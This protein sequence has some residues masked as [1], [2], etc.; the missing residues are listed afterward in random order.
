MQQLGTATPKNQTKVFF[1]HLGLDIEDFE[2]DDQEAILSTFYRLLESEDRGESPSSIR[3]NRCNYYAPDDILDIPIKFLVELVNVD[4]NHETFEYYHAIPALLYRKDWSKP[5]SKKE[6][7][8]NQELYYTAPLIFSLWAVS[9]F[10]DLIVTLQD[11]YP[12][13]YKGDTSEGSKEQDGRKMYGLIKIL[14]NKD[15]T[16]MKAAEELEIW[17]AFTWIEQEKIDLINQ[18]NA[19][20][21]STN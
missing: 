1:K 15:A 4:L 6:Y 11:N 3:Y 16:K 2:E 13:L 8:E 9:L 19:N 17:R 10:N 5:F 21:N 18:K 14:A 7:L 20:S 12:I